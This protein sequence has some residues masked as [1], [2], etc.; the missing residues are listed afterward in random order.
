MSNG[1]VMQES[2]PIPNTDTTDGQRA[3]AIRW[4]ASHAQNAQDLRHLL[5]VLGL[6]PKEVR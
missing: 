1:D 5:D 6:D 4:T 2:N 3:R